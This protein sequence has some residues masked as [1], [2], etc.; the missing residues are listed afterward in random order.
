MT[1]AISLR[2]NY[3]IVNHRRNKCLNEPINLAGEVWNYLI[4]YR[5]WVYK[6]FGKSVSKLDMQKHVGALRRDVA[7]FQHWQSLNL[8]ALREICDRVDKAYARFY[9][10]LKKGVSV[11]K[12]GLPRFRKRWKHRSF[13]LPFSEKHHGRGN[14][15]GCKIIDWG[16]NGYGKIRI[17]FGKKGI[18]KRVFKFH[19]GNRP[20]S[21]CGT[22]KSV[23]I[24]RTSDGRFYLSF[25][26]ERELPKVSYPSTGKIGGFDFG[27][28]N[29]LMNDEG[30]A[31]ASPAFLLNDLDKL[32]RRSKKLSGRGRKTLGSGSWVREKLNV[33]RLHRKIANRRSDF[34]WK[35]AHQLCEEYDVLC[36]ETLNLDGM[37]RVKGWGRKISD[38]GFADFL[39]KLEWVAE[40]TGREVQYAGKWYA[41]SQI[42]SRC[43]TK[44]E[45]MRGQDALK[46]RSFKC[47]DCGL[48]INRDHNAAI[49]IRAQSGRD[50][51]LGKSRVSDSK[52]SSK[53]VAP[54]LTAE[55]SV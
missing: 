6:S 29:F 28:T 27:L 51:V 47:G 55:P 49:N 54:V 30:H 15:N 33:A 53:S 38:L 4:A 13:V 31:I 11:R 36:F 23:S 14:G 34:H 52:T 39:R 24:I 45:N 40:K 17:S 20:L 21:E 44:N 46:E 22:L 42:C 48:V 37:K 16:E 5:K 19:T 2:Q 35:L 25:V 3:Q 41:S 8:Q 12:A 32:R 18:N 7:A 1:T 9:D 10:N 26:S 43:G 50:S